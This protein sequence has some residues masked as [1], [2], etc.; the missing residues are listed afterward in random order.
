[1][2]RPHPIQSPYVTPRALFRAAWRERVAMSRRTI[3][4]PCSARW[5]LR[6]PSGT[7]PPSQSSG[8][9]SR[10]LSNLLHR[11]WSE[12]GLARC[13]SLAEFTGPHRPWAPLGPQATLLRGILV[14]G[15]AGSKTP[16]FDTRF[17]LDS[18]DQRS[19]DWVSIPPPLSRKALQM[20]GFSLVAGSARWGSRFLGP[21]PSV[22]I[23]VIISIWVR[24][25]VRGKPDRLQMCSACRRGAWDT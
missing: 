11:S 6:L 4:Q 8:A 19:Q 24:P 5:T 18:G 1:M 25:R 14:P 9:I 22:T 23:S 2:L 15:T 16:R 12:Y 17:P 3:N 13:R 21:P 10:L 20:Q 7:H